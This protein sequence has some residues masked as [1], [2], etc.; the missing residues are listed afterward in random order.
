MSNARVE[1]GPAA[2]DRAGVLRAAMVERLRELG[3]V[4]G[5]EVARAFATV[6][7]HLFAPGASLEAAYAPENTVLVR[8]DAAGS[9]VSTVSAPHIQAMMLGQA[10][11][12]PGMRVLEVGSGGY[13]AALLAELVGPSGAVTT[14]DI[15][16]EVVDRARACLAAAGYDRVSV[17]LADADAG[18]PERAP[19]D[20]VLVT[21]GMWDIPPA[22]TD[23]LAPR[24]RLVVPLR[25]RG[26]TRSVVFEADGGRLVS[27]GYELCSFVPVRGAGAHLDQV[28]RLD[29]DDAAI[30]FEDPPDADPALVRQAVS[31]PRVEVWSGTRIGEG[32]QFE[33]LLL[34]LA[35]GLDNFGLLMARPAAVERGVVGHAWPLGVPTIVGKGSFAYLALSPKSPGQESREFGVYAHGP[36]ADALAERMAARIRTWDGGS[37][38]ARIEAFPAGTPDFVL[39]AGAV[40]LDRRHRRLALS[41]PSATDLLI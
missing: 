29:G 5:E 13:D 3:A 17:V 18:V 11:V 41:W 28:I 32:G 9:L 27:R 34:W 26:L 10:Q 39:P 37:R 30:R 33:G 19:F 38:T 14:V 23:Q 36:D 12:R 2:D 4:R 22:F 25:L 7:R 35:T 6:P 40:V 20:L 8:R 1:P 24:G 31:W 16:P 21:T 15:D